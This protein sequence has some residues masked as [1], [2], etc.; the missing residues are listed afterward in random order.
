MFFLLCLVAN[1]MSIA[2]PMPIPSGSFRPSRI[3]IGPVL[4][5]LA[6]FMIFPFVLIPT[7]IPLGADLLLAEFAGTDGWPI[8]LALSVAVFA[9]VL[10]LYQRVLTW[11]GEL[12]SRHEQ[13]IL[14]VVTAKE[15]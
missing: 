2:A 1:G 5:Q 4:L 14:E 13:A 6:F 15:E 10:W 9:L 8:G 12:F 3:K 11:E 7:M